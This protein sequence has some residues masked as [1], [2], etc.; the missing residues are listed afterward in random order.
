MDIVET[1][2]QRRSIRAFNPDPVPQQVLRQ[3]ME[4]ALHAPSWANTQPWEFALV[5][6]GKLKEIKQAFLERADE[7][8]HPDLPGPREFPEPYNSRRRGLVN[9]VAEIMQRERQDTEKLRQWQ[10]Q[11][12]GLY[13]TPVAIYIYTDRSFCYQGD[14]FNVWPIFDCGLV[15]QNIMLLATK[16]GLGT[17][18]QMQAVHHPDIL[19]S[20][21]DIPDSKLI[22]LGIAIGYPDW[23]DM[24]NNIRSERDGL[25]AVASWHGFD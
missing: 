18:P 10:R 25:D 2:Q 21:L 6:G 1:I 8:F 5:A 23:D 4:L 24:M 14:S 16:H 19:R 13:G 7:E 15:S 12:L 11:G 9:K 17:I 22:V 20:V 3:I